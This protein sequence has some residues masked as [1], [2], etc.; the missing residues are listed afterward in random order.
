M[1]ERYWIKLYHEIL[2]D[3]KMATLNDSQWRFVIELFLI[4]GR[5]SSDGH[6]PDAHKIA[7]ILRRDEKVVEKQLTEIKKVGIISKNNTGWIVDHFFDRQQ[8]S[9]DAERK[10]QQRER[11]HQ[12]QYYGEKDVTNQSQNVT[13]N[14]LTDTEQNRTE[15]DAS[16]ALVFKEYENNIELLTKRTSE[17]IGS[18]LDDKTP[19]EWIIDAIHEAADHGARNWKYIEAILKNWKAKGRGDKRKPTERETF[20]ANGVSSITGKKRGEK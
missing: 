18:W 5:T 11:D 19:P 17:A 20:D 6:I 15:L 16:I 1:S 12:K 2:D 4:A 8:P 3:P 9:T 10:R 7:W 13:Q 14:R